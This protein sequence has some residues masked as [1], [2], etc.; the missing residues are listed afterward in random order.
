MAKVEHKIRA[1]SN[2]TSSAPTESFSTEAAI[3][4]PFQEILQ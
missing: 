4:S 1:K 2:T 3:L